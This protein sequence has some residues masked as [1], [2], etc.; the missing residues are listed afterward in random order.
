MI[1]KKKPAQCQVWGCT[2]EAKFRCIESGLKYCEKH[3]HAHGPQTSKAPFD[4][5]HHEAIR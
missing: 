5:H 4:Y 3:K 2:N 1:G